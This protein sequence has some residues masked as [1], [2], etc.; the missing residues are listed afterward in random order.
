MHYSNGMSHI[1][2][3]VQNLK[4][5]GFQR[6]ALDQC[7]AFAERKISVEL[8]LLERIVSD[9]HNNFISLE[10][11][12]IQKYKISIK[13][14]TGSRLAQFKYF[15]RILRT[16]VEPIEFLSHSLRASVLI[17]LAGLLQ[18]KDYSV[19]STIHQIPSLSDSLQIKKRFFYALFSHR[20]FIFSAQAKQDWEARASKSLILRILFSRKPIELL[21][22]GVFLDR[23][24]PML[25]PT[26]EVNS[27]E[28][29]LVFIGR[30][31]SWKGVNTILHLAEN[32]A[33]DKAPLLF[34]F[35]YLNESVFMNTPG[36]IVER[37]SIEVGKSIRDYA[38]RLGDVHVYPANYGDESSYIESI[39]INCLEMSAIGVP[40]L[41]TKGG[42]ST[43]PE[44]ANSPLIYEVDWANLEETARKIS[45]IHRYSIAYE[46]ILRFRS[47]I[48]INKHIDQLI[49]L[50]KN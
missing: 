2:I 3:V 17:R 22:N 25:T 15:Y 33:I 28:V 12:L 40:S 29:R 49:T 5:G 31:I 20:L 1:V 14:S 38:P 48:D 37:I 39:S 10:K 16:S 27:P 34:F 44:F 4:I 46:E 8:I 50:T 30:P 36:R 7:Y 13:Y 6:I 18:K 23:L 47:L 21:R 26:L 43:W 19:N 9:E 11:D 24:P 42:L 35:P 45:D 41:V 32:G